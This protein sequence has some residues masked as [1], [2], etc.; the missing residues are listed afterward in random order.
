MEGVVGAGVVGG[1][2]GAVVPRVDV[3]LITTSSIWTSSAEL[4]WRVTNLRLN[5]VDDRYGDR[6]Y[7][8]LCQRSSSP[9]PCDQE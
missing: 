5:A 8:S 3:A 9:V 1:A 7:V 6:S 2:V 4:L